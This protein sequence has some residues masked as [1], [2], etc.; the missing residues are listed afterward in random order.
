MKI[1]Q[2]KKEI[3]TKING[4]RRTIDCI[5]FAT[6]Y[7]ANSYDHLMKMHMNAM[8][9][10]FDT[11]SKANRFFLDRKTPPILI[12]PSSLVVTIAPIK[13]DH[14]IR[15]LAVSSHAGDDILKEMRNKTCVKTMTVIAIMV[16]IR[17]ASSAI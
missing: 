13:I 14:I 6:E 2:T 17:P 9:R 5:D 16:P 7:T 15:N 12:C 8:H 1:P 3:C 4:I 10:S 11:I